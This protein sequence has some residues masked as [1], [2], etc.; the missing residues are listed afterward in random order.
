MV[1]SFQNRTNYNVTITILGYRESEVFQIQNNSLVMN[2]KPIRGHSNELPSIL[3]KEVTFNI[4]SNSV[5]DYKDLL[6]NDFNVS[7]QIGAADV[8]YGKIVPFAATE[9]IKPAPYIF[10]IVAIDYAR[11]YDDAE[12]FE[13]IDSCSD[14]ILLNAQ[15]IWRKPN[16]V[17]DV[18][19]Y[20]DIFDL[21][22]LTIRE[23]FLDNQTYKDILD[24]L[25]KSFL[26]TVFFLG[27]SDEVPSVWFHYYD[28][29]N[30]ADLPRLQAFNDPFLSFDPPVGVATFEQVI[31]DHTFNILL[32]TEPEQSDSQASCTYYFPFQ[33]ALNL[34][35]KPTVEVQLFDNTGYDIT[36][37]VFTLVEFDIQ[38]IL[39]NGITN[40]VYDFDT[41]DW[42]DGGSYQLNI[43]GGNG[44]N[45][46]QRSYDYS[47]KAFGGEDFYLQV[48]ITAGTNR[49]D[50][51]GVPTGNDPSGAVYLGSDYF[52][53]FY[54]VEFTTNNGDNLTETQTFNSNRY[55]KSRTFET[56]FTENGFDTGLY[57]IYNVQNLTSVFSENIRTFL[58]NQ[59][60]NIQIYF[61]GELLWDVDRLSVPY[62][63]FKYDY[64]EGDKLFTG[65]EWNVNLET[66][67]AS[68]RFI[69]RRF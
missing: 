35:I 29:Y 48:N 2:F 66:M 7:I 60:S 36:S 53:I 52:N 55:S 19:R 5:L 67:I 20:N 24:K 68:G 46:F 44:V 10:R 22:V 17:A 40:Y 33:Q 69:Q 12:V 41:E 49:N 9:P 1:C 11:N 39:T 34:K 21:S 50:Y 31:E 8:F 26:C 61:E 27:Y 13:A 42:V 6:F 25:S 56:Y 14:T 64:G 32:A 30:L 58:E 57:Y 54:D 51:F 37:I 16:T 43:V 4:L 23:R 28:T 59:Y 3:A 65:L 38:I 18:T 63:P 62:L 15:Q 45:N 47:L